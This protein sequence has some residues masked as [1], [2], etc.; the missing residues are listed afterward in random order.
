MAWTVVTFDARV[1]AEL[2]DLPAACERV[3]VGSRI[4]LRQLDC[5]TYT[6]LT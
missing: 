4:L 6:S 3:I 2:D 1:D 5:K